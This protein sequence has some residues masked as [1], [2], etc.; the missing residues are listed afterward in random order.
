M[1]E[2]NKIVADLVMKLLDTT[3][4]VYQEIKYALLVR[5]QDEPIIVRFLYEV[6]EFVENRR[7]LLI[8]MKGDVCNAAN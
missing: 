4:D 2:F 7:P 5:M 1:S 3:P 6:F 8:E